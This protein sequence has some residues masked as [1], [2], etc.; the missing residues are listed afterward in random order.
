MV[1]LFRG[2]LF[3]KISW[4]ICRQIDELTDILDG[5]IIDWLMDTTLL[6]MNT[7]HEWTIMKM[8]WVKCYTLK[9]CKMKLTYQIHFA[10]NSY[11]HKHIVEI[12]YIYIY[13]NSIWVS[14]SHL[15]WWQTK[16]SIIWSVLN[17]CDRAII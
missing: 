17:I 9:Y 16:C 8:Y 11:T 1:D 15:G 4:W 5:W 7:D 12:I 3:F 13:Y 2:W 14:L 6:S 10:D